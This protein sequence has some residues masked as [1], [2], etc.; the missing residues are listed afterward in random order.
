[1]RVAQL[2]LR[3]C[4]SLRVRCIII[5]IKIPERLINLGR[6]VTN[7]GSRLAKHVVNL[8]CSQGDRESTKVEESTDLGHPMRALPLVNT[9]VGVKCRD[10]P[11]GSGTDLS[12]LPVT[13]PHDAERLVSGDACVRPCGRKEDARLMRP[14]H[15]FACSRL[16]TC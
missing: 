1:M 15:G 8:R 2:G 16:F 14:F 3:P 5:F 13:G 6:G 9:V 10:C 11:D 7:F 12:C 4:I